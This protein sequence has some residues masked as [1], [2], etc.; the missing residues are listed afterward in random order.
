MRFISPAKVRKIFDICKFKWCFIGKS[1]RF[2]K[3]QDIYI[4]YIGCCGVRRE[5]DVP[6]INLRSL[7]GGGLQLEPH[8]L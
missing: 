1:L 6:P 3:S 5:S 8:I 2:S 7:V 4:V